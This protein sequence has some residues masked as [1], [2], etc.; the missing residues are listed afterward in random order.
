MKAVNGRV[1]RAPS[2]KDCWLIG[3]QCWHDG[4]SLYAEEHV[5]PVI[6]LCLQS[7]NHETA[8]E[9]LQREYERHFE[10]DLSEERS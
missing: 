9:V 5:W 3:G 8:W 2:H 4:T 10:R 7:G 1:D 6:G